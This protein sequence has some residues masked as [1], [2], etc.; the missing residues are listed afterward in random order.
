[1]QVTPQSTTQKPCLSKMLTSSPEEGEYKTKKRLPEN[2]KT[3]ELHQFIEIQT[4]LQNLIRC[5]IGQHKMQTKIADNLQI[6]KCRLRPKLLHHLIC[7]MFSIC[8][9]YE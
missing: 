4:T 5:V 1:M 7:N 6:E 2:I 3:C 9:L 8:D